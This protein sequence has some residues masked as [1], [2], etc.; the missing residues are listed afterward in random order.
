MYGKSLKVCVCVYVCVSTEGNSWQLK[1]KH[2]M[3]HLPLSQRHGS[4]QFFSFSHPSLHESTTASVLNSESA[5]TGWRWHHQATRQVSDVPLLCREQIYHES[6]ISL[7]CVYNLLTINS[8]FFF[9]TLSDGYIMSLVKD[10][11]S[12]WCENIKSAHLED[13]MEVKTSLSV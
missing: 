9:Q 11:V 13:T 2:V 3:N 6:H 12:R 10:G 8:L 1:Q 5:A 7:L 4:I